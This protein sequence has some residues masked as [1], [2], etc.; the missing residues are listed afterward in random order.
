MRKT[1]LETNLA[2]DGKL[3]SF[4]LGHVKFEISNANDGKAVRYLRMEISRDVWLI[5]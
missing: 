3:E 4:F 1:S 5:T 2:M